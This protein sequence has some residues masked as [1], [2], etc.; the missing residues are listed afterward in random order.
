MT[1]DGSKLNAAADDLSEHVA[2]S[3]D[4]VAE[5]HRE[6]FR[7]ATGVQ[8]AIDAVT[9]RLGRPSA[10]MGLLIALAAWTGAALYEAGDMSMNRF[11]A[12]LSS[13]RQSPPC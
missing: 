6:H 4:T 8:R 11:L 1:I 9:D 12:G 2:E 7:Q 10:L 3:V 13:Q 5:F